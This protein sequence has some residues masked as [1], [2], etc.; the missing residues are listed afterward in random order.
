MDV[1]R[2]KE[3]HPSFR[4]FFAP[5]LVKTGEESTSVLDLVMYRR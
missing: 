1:L 5:F 4:V 2:T 3:L